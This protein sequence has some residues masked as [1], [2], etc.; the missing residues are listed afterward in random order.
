MELAKQTLQVTQQCL[1]LLD[2]GEFEEY[3]RLETERRALMDK[4]LQA[5]IDDLQLLNQ[6]HQASQALQNELEKI[7]FVPNP[8]AAAEGYGQLPSGSGYSAEA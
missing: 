8:A 7:V 6:V 5:K 4:L 1:D 2:R 3:T